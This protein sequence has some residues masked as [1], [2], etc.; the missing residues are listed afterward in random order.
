MALNAELPNSFLKKNPVTHLSI[1]LCQNALGAQGKEQGSLCLGEGRE[2][3]E[4]KGGQR[5]PEEDGEEKRRHEG[6]GWRWER[7]RAENLTEEM[8]KRRIHPFRH[9]REEVMI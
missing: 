3:K 2:G 8:G 7:R 6:D 4:G 1:S 5:G 9:T